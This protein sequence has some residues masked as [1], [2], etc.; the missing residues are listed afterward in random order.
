MESGAMER[1]SKPDAQFVLKPSTQKTCV[2]CK[3]PKHKILDYLACRVSGKGSN[4]E[5]FKAP[6]K[7]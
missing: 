5:R 6:F 1:I 4:S 7:D 3:V 2:L